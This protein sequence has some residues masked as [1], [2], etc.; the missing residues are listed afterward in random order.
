MLNDEAPRFSVR[1]IGLI[2]GFTGSFVFAYAN[3]SQQQAR[4]DERIEMLRAEDSRQD[5]NIADLTKI[6]AANAETIRAMAT[7]T[8]RTRDRVRLLE[9][10]RPIGAQK[11]GEG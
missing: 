3:L 9:G 6:A 10:G 5:S 7:E 11:G 4:A 8:E 2:V 1:D